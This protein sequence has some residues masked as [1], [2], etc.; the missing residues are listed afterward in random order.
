VYQCE[1]YKSTESKLWRKHQKKGG[2][3]TKAIAWVEE[4]E[5]NFSNHHFAAKARGREEK[6]TIFQ[7]REKRMTSI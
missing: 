3:Y 2:K 7:K 1:K 5:K 4:S 6:G